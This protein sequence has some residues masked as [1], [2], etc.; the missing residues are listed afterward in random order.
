MILKE[1]F[2]LAEREA[3]VPDRDF[4]IV[5]VAWLARVSEDGRI[6]GIDDHRSLVQ[7]KGAPKYRAVNLR[8]PRPPQ[9]TSGDRSAFLCDKSEYVFGI[10]LSREPGRRRSADRLRARAAL[11]REG[12]AACATATGDPGAKAVLGALERVAA[13][14]SVVQL[15]PDAAP[16]DLFAFILASD[17][18]TPVHLRPAVV[19]YWRGRRPTTSHAIESARFTCIVTGNPVAQP[20][21]FRKVKHIPGGV[22]SGV[23]LVSFNDSA[24]ESYGWNRNENAPISVAAS[25]ACSTALERLVHPAFP[26]PSPD[27]AGETLPRRNIRLGGTTVVAYWASDPGADRVLDVFGLALENPSDPGVVAALYAAPYTARLPIVP[28]TARLYALTLAGA[29]G[30]VMV[31][32]WFETSV[33]AAERNLRMY[34]EDLS[35][36]RNTPAPRTGSLAPVPPLTTQLAALAPFGK[37]KSV[38]EVLGTRIIRAALGGGPFPIAVLQRA[39]ERTRA[40]VGQTGWADLDRRDARAALIKATLNRNQRMAPH[41]PTFPP[42]KSDMDPSN[43]NQG[44]L[45]GRLIAVIERLQQLALGSPNASVVD[46]YFGAASAAPRGVFVRILKN[47]RHHARKAKDA[48]PPAPARAIWLER[49][50]DDIADRFDP[51]HNGFPA[52]LTLEEQGLFVLGYHQQRHW[53]NLTRDQREG[54]QGPVNVG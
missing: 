27:M 32:D 20:G 54:R 29:Q 44:Y 30:R 18:D 16:N 40:E 45:L 37:W 53:L 1:L 51:R 14:A 21:N 10:D 8:I 22:S 7:T 3:L 42:L 24:F 49:Q 11:F 43:E 50:L 33:A 46:R 6:V 15:P 4:E 25:E 13:D 52:A 31:R 12:V 9:R 5:P 2:D 34:F 26:N 48:D 38:P 36:V 19:E 35:I 39:I 41:T 23:P 47:A 28:P 17:V